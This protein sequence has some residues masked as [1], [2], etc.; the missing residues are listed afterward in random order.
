LELYIRCRMS[1]LEGNRLRRG[2]DKSFAQVA[3]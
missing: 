2:L 3:L 1:R